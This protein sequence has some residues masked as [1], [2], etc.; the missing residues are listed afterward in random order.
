MS[1]IAVNTSRVD[2]TIHHVVLSE[3]QI[4]ALIVGSVAKAAGVEVD[5]C[6]VKV[7]Q[8]YLTRRDSVGSGAEY[9]AT[10]TIVVDH[11]A[12]N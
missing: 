1:K 10:C 11:S 8:F 4:R 5:G 2:E 12:A 6:S 7:R 3:A 9:G